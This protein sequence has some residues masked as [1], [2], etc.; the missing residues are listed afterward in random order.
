MNQQVNAVAG[1][2]RWWLRLEGLAVLAAAVYVYAWGG[3]SW[4]LFAAL[5]LAPDLGFLG[6]LAGPRT[7]AAVYNVLHSYVI[8]VAI[9]AAFHA[10]NRP[11][12]L[13]LIWIAHIGFDRLLGYGLKYPSAFADTHL[14]RIG[15]RS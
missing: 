14:G 2:V 4:I 12:V 10:M 5:F 7:G 1:P 13:P 6:Y 11:L 9:A 3:H 15:R 8:P